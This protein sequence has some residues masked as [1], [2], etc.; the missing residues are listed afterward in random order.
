MYIYIY[1]NVYTGWPTK[2]YPFF[3]I[4]LYKKVWATPYIYNTCTC[5]TYM[6]R[7][8]YDCYICKVLNIWSGD[9]V[10]TFMML[11]PCMVCATL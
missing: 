4:W 8:L 3:Y 1:R 5:Y 11:N 9:V 10:L 7:L 6:Y 2:I